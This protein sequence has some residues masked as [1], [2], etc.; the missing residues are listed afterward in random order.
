[1]LLVT[2]L[3][4]PN[5]EAAKQGQWLARLGG[6]WLPGKRRVAA[7]SGLAAGALPQGKESGNPWGHRA[8]TTNGLFTHRRLGEGAGMHSLLCRAQRRNGAWAQACWESGEGGTQPE[9]PG[10]GM[11]ASN[12]TLLAGLFRKDPRGAWE[13]PGVLYA[14]CSACVATA[15]VMAHSYY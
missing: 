9:R 8:P 11:V 7:V 5:V 15:A 14:L 2:R 4:P 13:T 6:Q 12:S 1:M 10:V 3:A